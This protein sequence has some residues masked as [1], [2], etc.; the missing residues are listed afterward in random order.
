M[1]NIVFISGSISI[2]ELPQQVKGSID[3]IMKQNFE[4]LV[5][6]SKGIDTLVQ[7]YCLSLNYYNITIYSIYTYPRYKASEKFKVKYIKVPSSIKQERQRQQ[8]KDKAMTL[9]SKFTFAI[10]DSKS[11]GSYSNI[12]RGLNNNKKVK[13]YLFDKDLFLKQKETIIDKIDFIYRENNGYTALE[14]IKYLKNG[15]FK[16]TQDLNRYLTEKLIIVKNNNTY[17]PTNEYQNLFIIDKYRGRVKGI[18]FK[19]EFISWIEKYIQED[20]KLQQ[21]RL[22]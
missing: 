18:K 3:K 12:I 8:E 13:V 10:W 19:N 17:I 22:F 6:D 20:R 15:I 5:G 2:R 4:I 14:V 21:P 16:R 1:K 9:N 11:F 7:N